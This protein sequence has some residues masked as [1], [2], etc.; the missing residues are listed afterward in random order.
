MHTHR[1]LALLAFAAALLL[2]PVAGPAGAQDKKEPPVVPPKKG[3]TETIA[4]F[5][6]KAV[7]RA[8]HLDRLQAGAKVL[9]IPADRAVIEAAVAETLGAAPHRHGILRITVTRGAGVRG[10]A[11]D[12]TMPS[13]LVTLSP[14]IKGML[15]QPVKLVTSTIRR[16]E[17]SPAARLKTLSYV[18]NILAAREAAARV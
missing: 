14:W 3:K 13:L 5:N 6:G 12:G 4:V 15:L 10:L 7:W 8:D 9:G 1:L 17:T 2:T 11:A 16:N 18:D